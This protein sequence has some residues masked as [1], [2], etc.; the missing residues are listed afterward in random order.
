MD[1]TTNVSDTPVV[2]SNANANEAAPN[3]ASAE[4]VK[5]TNAAKRIPHADCIACF[6]KHKKINKSDAGKQFRSQLRRTYA[7]RLK[8]DA[9]AKHSHGA[10]YDS[11]SIK[12]LRVSFP[13]IPANVWKVQKKS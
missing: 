6:A 1:I 2:E 4:K 8:V 3:E 13:D 12:G 11:H 5:R 9:K 10:D 7:E